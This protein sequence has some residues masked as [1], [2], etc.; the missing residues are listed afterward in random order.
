[1]GGQ[2]R[3]GNA[4][5]S[6]TMRRILVTGGSGFIGTNL[7][8]K[9]G[10]DS[11][12]DA[13]CNIDI[14]PPR[15]KAHESLWKDV[16]ILRRDA[17]LRVFD[18]FRPTHVVHLA[19]EVRTE[20]QD[21]SLFRANT[22]GV[23]NIVTACAS[24]RGIQLAVF[25]STKLVHDTGY[26]QKHVEDY[27][28]DTTY[29]RSKVI[30]EKIVRED[31]AMKCAWT[32]VRPASIWGPHFDLTEGYSSFFRLVSKRMYFHPGRRD[33]LKSFGY[34]ENS[35]F[36]LLKIF[37]APEELV[38]SETFYISDYETFTIREWACAIAEAV[39]QKPPW[40]LP[41]TAMKL[42]AKMGDL[43]LCMRLGVPLMSSTRLRNM[44]LDTRNFDLEPME[45]ITGPLPFTM[46]EGV[47]RTVQWMRSK[48]ALV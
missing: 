24:S 33:P 15:L 22:E 36:Q 19:A 20:L 29:G 38:H 16:N 17:L 12:E 41:G 32:I 5:R 9:I 13:V 35:V 27:C 48:G 21:M 8:E 1:M 37:S 23:E 11:P 43:K 7:I 4:D 10:I 2:T 31:R 47:E 42:L 3:S 26:R 34:V 6:R 39:G 46:R 40:M 28:P 30:G 14:A 44:W 45:R 18:E 25:V